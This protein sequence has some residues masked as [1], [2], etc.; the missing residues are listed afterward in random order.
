MH[1][2]GEAELEPIRRTGAAHG[3]VEPTYLSVAGLSP[4]PSPA[5]S[6][7]I[8]QLVESQTFM[9]E[10][11]QRS[12]QR[13]AE[14]GA[15]ATAPAAMTTPPEAVRII[16]P[17]ATG[18]ADDAVSPQQAT[19]GLTPQLHATGIE[20]PPANFSL[21]GKQPSPRPTDSDGPTRHNKAQRLSGDSDAPSSKPASRT[22]SDGAEQV[23]TEADEEDVEEE[24]GEEEG[25]EGESSAASDEDDGLQRMVQM[26]Q[27]QQSGGSGRSKAAARQPSSRP[28]AGPAA[29][30][31]VAEPEPGWDAAVVRR[32]G[33][34]G[35]MREPPEAGS[36]VSTAPAPDAPA[37]ATASAPV[38]DPDDP[39][40]DWGDFYAHAKDASHRR[41]GKQG[42]NVRQA[43]ERNYAIQARQA[44]RG[45]GR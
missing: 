29:P 5:A 27:A 33:S 9:A 12:G 45:S 7:P 26:R 44:Q 6:R 43:M 14:G 23:L 32:R 34:N 3:A 13:A 28:A 42:R 35:V 38:D 19:T 8:G 40:G 1:A 20:I 36:P 15:A 10:R 16:V 17:V 30:A 21:N 37:A 2:L 18:A 31:M 24:E 4:S 39:E 22:Q 25:E 11:V 41:I